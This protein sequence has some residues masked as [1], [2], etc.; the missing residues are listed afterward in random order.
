ML[1][2]A[3]SAGNSSTISTHGQLTSS[4]TASNYFHLP[5]D[6]EEDADIAAYERK[7]L[8]WVADSRVSSP[9]SSLQEQSSSHRS[10]RHACSADKSNPVQEILRTNNLY[11]LLG[12]PK[13]DNIDH[14]TLRRAYLA[15]SRVCHP[16]FVPRPSSLLSSSNLT[17]VNS[18]MTQTRPTPSKRSPLPMTSSQIPPHDACMIRDHPHTTLSLRTPQVMQRRHSGA[19]SLVYLMT[20]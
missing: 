8:T 12:V 4:P 19:L 18:P 9:S 11:D 17:L 15:R 1:S 2:F 16:E 13:S 20:F 3:I 6:E 14:M 10:K 5:I 7:Y